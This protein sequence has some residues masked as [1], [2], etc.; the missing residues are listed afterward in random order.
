MKFMITGLPRSRTAW[1]AA[2]FSVAG[3]PCIHEPLAKADNFRHA[4]HILNQFDGYSDSSGPEVYG[5]LAPNRRVIIRRDPA[6]VIESLYEEFDWPIE[7]TRDKVLAMDARLNDM[8]GWHVPYDEI[9]DKLEAIHTYCTDV[10]YDPLIGETYKNMK[11][12]IIDNKFTDWYK[13]RVEQ[14]GVLDG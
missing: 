6:R 10:P 3:I 11:V 9:N 7:F 1:F 13:K 12:S 8:G 2:Y 14:S 5:P 4:V